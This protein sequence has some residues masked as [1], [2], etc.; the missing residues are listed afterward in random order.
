MTCSCVNYVSM[1]N[2][3]LFPCFV[4][5]D[6]KVFPNILLIEYQQLFH[7]LNILQTHYSCRNRGSADPNKVRTLG[8]VRRSS[9][10]ATPCSLL[11]G[12]GSSGSSE[13]QEGVDIVV[14]PGSGHLAV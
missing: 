14:Y 5:V 11:H 8:L 3:L 2:D 9:L 12:L 6:Y 13:R 10:A 1:R 7:G 4:M